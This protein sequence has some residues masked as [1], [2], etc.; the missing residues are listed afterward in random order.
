MHHLRCFI[1]LVLIPLSRLK[2][3]DAPLLEPGVRVRVSTAPKAS[4]PDWI[5]GTVTAVTGDRLA[6]RPQGDSGREIGLS[7]LRSRVSK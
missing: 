3:Q 2:A 1:A 4:R 6:I 5:V 7:A